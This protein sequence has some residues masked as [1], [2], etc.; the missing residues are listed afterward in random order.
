MNFREKLLGEKFLITAELL[1][2]RGT[3]PG[4]LLRQAERLS[5]YVDAFNL[6]DNP[7]A[8]LHTA[9]LGLAHVLQSY[10]FESIYQV[11]CR[12]RNRLALQA[13]LLTAGVLGVWNVLALTGDHNLLGDHPGS[14]PVYDMDS[15]QLLR[16]LQNFN[17]GLDANE[18]MLENSTR[19]CYGAVVNP[20]S[21]DINGQ[22][23]KLKR[24]IEYGVSFIQ[25]QAVFDWHTF[26]F[27]KTLSKDISVKVLAGIIPLR[28]ARMARWI[29][30][31][32]P[33]VSIPAE[34]LRRL[35]N[36]SDPVL[37]GWRIVDETV[38]EIIPDCNGLHFMPLGDAEGLLEYL[39]SFSR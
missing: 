6:P 28:S 30:S 24:K 4:K 25:T 32:I 26:K 8:R 1:P 22:V 37:E 13:D 18:R 16:L 31:H 21:V 27:F 23:C 29:N 19:F 38:S 9:P 5:P 36:A 11:T 7:G 35:E 10:G 12:D 17:N 15:I 39:K 3:D 33:G 34:I 14:K 2:P 20:S